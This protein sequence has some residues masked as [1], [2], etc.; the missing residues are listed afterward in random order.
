[1][2]NYEVNV[3]PVNI[4]SIQAIDFAVNVILREMNMEDAPYYINDEG[5]LVR[6]KV[7]MTEEGPKVDSQ[8]DEV[9]RVATDLDKAV[10]ILCGHLIRTRDEMIS[11]EA[12]NVG[13]AA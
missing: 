5:M 4:T 2:K 9:G 7:V 13:Q 3:P 11:V 12:S 1:M 10:F 8:A 6:Q